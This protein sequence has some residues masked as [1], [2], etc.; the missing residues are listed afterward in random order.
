MKVKVNFEADPPAFDL[1]DYS[2]EPLSC[3]ENSTDWSLA[4]PKIK[5]NENG[6]AL[7]EL[8]PSKTSDFF[9]LADD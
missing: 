5:N 1:D 8:L 7:I 2:T 6:D 3:G 4:L 9:V